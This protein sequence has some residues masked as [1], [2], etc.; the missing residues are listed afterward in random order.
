VKGEERLKTLLWV[1]KGL[2]EKLVS[3]ASKKHVT[4]SE[5]VSV[6]VQAFQQDAL[7]QTR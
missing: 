1:E 3:E 6:L 2:Y 7:K 4:V 5:C